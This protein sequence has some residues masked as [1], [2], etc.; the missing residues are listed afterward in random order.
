[1]KFRPLFSL[2]MNQVEENGLTELFKDYFGKMVFLSNN[3]YKNDLTHLDIK[4]LKA[5]REKLIRMMKFR[6]IEFPD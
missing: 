1:M 5:N 4:Y 3:A 6:S 2:M